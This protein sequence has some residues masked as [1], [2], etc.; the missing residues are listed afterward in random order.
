MTTPNPSNCTPASSGA[1]K[2]AGL[3]EDLWT[4][5]RECHQNALQELETKVSKLKKERCLDAQRL[6]EFY[7]RN[8][9]LKVQHKTLQDTISLLEE[10]LRAGVCDRCVVLE[11]HMRTKQGEFEKDHQQ[12]L[13][14][15]AKLKSENNSLQDVNGKLSMELETLKT[16]VSKPQQTLSPEQEEGVI[17]DSPI[18]STTLP[19]AN[20]LKRRKKEG[21]EKPVRY[22]ERPL[23]QPN[24]SLFNELLETSKNLGKGCVLVPNTCEMDTSQ[25]SQDANQ[26]LEEVVAETCRLDLPDRQNTEKTTVQRSS[27]LPKKC[28][29]NLRPHLSLS[30]LSHY[31]DHTVESSP[32]LLTSVKRLP[33]DSSLHKAKRKKEETVHE[34]EEE[35]TFIQ[36][37]AEGSHSPDV[38]RDAEK[39][40]EL[41]SKCVSAPP[42]SP[43]SKEP[44]NHNVWSAHNGASF[45]CPA[46]R[47]TNR[48]SEED[49]DSDPEHHSAEGKQRV[50]PMWSVDPAVVLSM[51]DTQS[52]DEKKGGPHSQE[53]TVDADCTFISRSVL[54]RQGLDDQDSGSG[55]SGLCQKA[56]DS[57]DRM[58]DTT[59]YGEYKSYNGS[60]LEQTQPC[61]D[62]HHDELEEEHDDCPPGVYS[63]EHKARNPTFAHVAVVRKKEERRKLKG[64]TCKECD[65]YYAHLPEEERQKKLS[66]CSRHRF[67]YVPPCT[68]ENFWEVGFPSTQ[69]C[70]ERGYIKEEKNPQPRLRRRQPLTALFSPKR[71][72]QNT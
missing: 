71:K 52:L 68:P 59:A 38:Q 40:P 37:G 51:Y 30:S 45:M 47:K 27:T 54:Q 67:L 64:A 57:L 2:S 33:G 41:I 6:E 28:K 60:H 63:K 10:R 31:P 46:M 70:I 16:S 36:Q 14:L 22:A 13:R 11:E 62:D 21:K 25:T 61:R 15:I 35:V 20:K 42:S 58:F 48:T 50:E 12:N 17:P 19:L 3:F 53:E 66:A 55:V 56:N 32:S 18:Q 43:N 44:A 72:E 34:V 23:A 26:T 8:Q 4:Q 65:V 69:T 49:V 39:P 29:V 1:T 9:Q 24:S 7:T 5:L